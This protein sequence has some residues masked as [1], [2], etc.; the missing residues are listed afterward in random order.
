[1]S[2]GLRRRL[3]TIIAAGATTVGIGLVFPHNAHAY[4]HFPPDP[5]RIAANSNNLLQFNHWGFDP[6]DTCQTQHSWLLGGGVL[7]GDVNQDGMLVHEVIIES[8]GPRASRDLGW[9]EVGKF[10]DV[11]LDNFNGRFFA[12]PD[13]VRTIYTIGKRV[14]L[15]QKF[16][17][18]VR[19]KGN[20]YEGEGE[21]CGGGGRHLAPWDIIAV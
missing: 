12:I 5:Q 2:I 9:H 21:W 11:P 20:W 19:P 3:L 1:M 17:L 7:T 16:E 10:Y 18:S 15:N 14:P 13:G 6:P 8:V 4:W